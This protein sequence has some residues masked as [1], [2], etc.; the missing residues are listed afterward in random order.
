MPSGMRQAVGEVSI[1]A[2]GATYFERTLD[3]LRKW[4]N[5]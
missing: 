1:T 3:V 5:W 2:R 4:R